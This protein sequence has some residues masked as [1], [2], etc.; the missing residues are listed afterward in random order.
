MQI[1]ENLTKKALEPKEHLP[2]G[3][4]GTFTNPKAVK[5]NNVQGRVREDRSNQTASNRFKP[6]PT[7]AYITTPLDADSYIDRT[8]ADAKSSPL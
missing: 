4:S 7:L 1:S 6:L 8:K 3:E 2:N 5:N